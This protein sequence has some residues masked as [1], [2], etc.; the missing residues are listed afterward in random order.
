[1]IKHKHFISGLTLGLLL[2]V[3]GLFLFREMPTL[4]ERYDI[5][6]QQSNLTEE[7]ELLYLREGIYNKL[8]SKDV[9]KL[10]KLN[11]YVLN[12]YACNFVNDHSAKSDGGCYDACLMR[13][14][15]IKSSDSKIYWPDGKVTGATDVKGDW[16]IGV[17]FDDYSEE[18]ANACAIVMFGGEF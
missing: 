9:A 1:M 8:T 10:V 13:S 2:G 3:A 11:Q 17:S 5:S 6:R 15:K 16:P 12:E 18:W 14:G 7:R 4:I